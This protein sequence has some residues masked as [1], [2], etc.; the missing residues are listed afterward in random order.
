MQK[1]TRLK[2][3]DIDSQ[4]MVVHIKQGKGG[5]DRDVPLSPKLLETLRE[6]WRWKKPQEYLFPGEAKQGSKGDHLTPKAVY[7][8][9][10]RGCTQSRH[11]EKGR[12]A[13]RFD[14]LLRLIFWN[15]ARICARFSFCL[16]MP[17]I[18]DIR[19]S[20]CICRGVICM[21]VRIRWMNCR[22]GSVQ[23]QPIPEE[24]G[25]VNRP[26]F[27]VADIIRAA[28]KD[29]IE[30]QR[31][32]LTGSAPQ[33]A[34]CHRALPYGSTRRSPGSLFS[35]RSYRRHLLQQLP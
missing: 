27:E 10:Q 8:A 1:L 34:F 32:W 17:A 19:R 3:S 23:R 25:T 14:T 20:I 31:S 33:G 4:R 28:G 35:M 7:Y 12:A 2:V 15:Q 6:Y 9:C 21:L 30:K 22:I 24:S 29:F 11:P 26:P 13:I 16:D 5:K 18:S